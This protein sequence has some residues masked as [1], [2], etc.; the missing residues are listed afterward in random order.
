M[1]VTPASHGLATRPPQPARARRAR[2]D[3]LRRLRRAAAFDLFRACD[4]GPPPRSIWPFVDDAE[5][6]GAG[7][8]RFLR[9]A[10]AGPGRAAD[11]SALVRAETD[12]RTLPASQAAALRGE[13]LCG[14]P[15]RIDAALQAAR[16]RRSTVATSSSSPDDLA[17]E[18]RRLCR[19]LVATWPEDWVGTSA[20]D[21]L[22][23]LFEAWDEAELGLAAPATRVSALAAIACSAE[24]ISFLADAARHAAPGDPPPDPDAIAPAA[25]DAATLEAELATLP[26]HNAALAL[27]RA[28][29]LRHHP[30][31]PALDVSARAAAERAAVAADRALDRW[32]RSARLAGGAAQP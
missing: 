9:A 6:V 10:G 14:D 28:F 30:D 1:P 16:N 2:P 4:W 31:R 19:D 29:R 32:E 25:G 11:L 27:W 23:A 22:R 24:Q 8:E 21:R 5:D 3:R 7:V 18:R 13:L 26:D 15:V 20:G 17:D 12:L